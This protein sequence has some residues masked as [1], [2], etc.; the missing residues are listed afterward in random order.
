MR[1]APHLQATT[2]LDL[3]CL[4]FCSFFEANAAAVVCRQLGY[5]AH[6]IPLPLPLGSNGQT[7]PVLTQP[8]LLEQAP[9]QRRASGD[10]R[11]ILSMQAG[12]QV[13]KRDYVPGLSDRR[14]AL[15]VI[16]SAPRPQAGSHLPVWLT[17][18]QCR[19][20]EASLADCIRGL[21]GWGRRVPGM[22]CGHDMDMGVWCTSPPP[23]KSW[24]P[25]ARSTGP[26]RPRRAGAAGS[27]G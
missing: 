19:G 16:A 21:D 9:T 14:H 17:D 27:L 1:A 2:L 25:P 11:M 22:P 18:Y 7:K 4:P 6:G 12:Q 23:P 26:P 24:E 10:R 20:S 5:A 15:D 13:Q 3:L 8:M